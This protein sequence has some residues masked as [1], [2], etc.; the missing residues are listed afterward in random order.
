MGLVSGFVDGAGLSLVDGASL[1]LAR[2]D[3]SQAFQMGLVS[4]LV[5]DTGLRLGRCNRS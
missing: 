2:L 5:D 4:G 1:R 3:W